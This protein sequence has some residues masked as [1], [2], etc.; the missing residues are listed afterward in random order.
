MP[1]TTGAPEM[2]EAGGLE[3]YYQ[4][5][6]FAVAVK[7]AS[8]QAPLP[9]VPDFEDTL[10]RLL[11]PFSAAMD[12]GPQILPPPTL[13]PISRPSS[14]S[15]SASASLTQLPGISSLAAA[16][17]AVNSPQLRCVN[18]PQ[19]RPDIR[20]WLSARNENYDAKTVFKHEIWS[21]Q[22]RLCLDEPNR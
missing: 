2:T 19:R 18:N 3:R 1:R 5:I 6:R 21:W 20:R 13:E 10:E 7:L 16:N 11:P 17:A 22:R 9:P 12:D 8:D 15:T 14:T 4:G